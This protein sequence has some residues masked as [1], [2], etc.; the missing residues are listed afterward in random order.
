MPRVN[1]GE[2]PA[3]A[4]PSLRPEHGGPLD[5]GGPG[6]V[7][8]ADR[9]AN[10]R[11]FLAWI[12]TSLALITF[13]FVIAKFGVWLRQ[14]SVGLRAAGASVTVRQSGTSLPTGL[15]LMIFGAAVAVLALVRHRRVDRALR[16]GHAPPESRMAVV[17]AV[18]V[19]I[20]ALLLSVLLVVTTRGL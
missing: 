4:G 17:V 2:G 5:R 15:A 1:R 9:L 12:R 8:P 10:E 18:A 19:V 13:G 6:P 11:T 14:F 20:V 16:A 3:R 7:R